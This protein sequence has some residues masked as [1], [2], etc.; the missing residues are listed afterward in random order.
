MIISGVEVST[1]L[2]TE[3]IQKVELLKK[4]GIDP[5]LATILVGNDQASA[6]YI[7]NKHKACSDLGIK[8]KDNTMPSA[9]EEEKLIELIN[10]LNNDPSVH[11]ILLQLPLPSH[12]DQ[13]EV[14]NKIKP[15]KDVDGLTYQNAGLLLNKKSSLIPCTP[16]GVMELFNYYKIELE[17]KDIVIINRS[18]L[19]GKPLFLLLLEKD[20][21]VT[22][23][24]SKTRNLEEK[25]R[26][27]DIIITAVGNRKLFT[28]K[29]E[30][31]KED[32]VII[33]IGI[34]RENGKII[35]DTDFKRV[36]PKASWITPVPGGV[37]P[38][39]ITMLLNNTIKA[40]SN[41]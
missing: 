39:T 16:L 7:R 12:I 4:K 35:G 37:G 27:A 13:F 28:L 41:F 5:C 31:V 34:S 32:V 19:V 11:G 40:A 33:D 14:I 22:I 10:S 6:I 9:I 17:G 25:L 26:R 21:T 30:H 3:L 8:T 23:C 29:P 20:A 18:I 2:K 15:T 36:A 24:H 38:M 1:K